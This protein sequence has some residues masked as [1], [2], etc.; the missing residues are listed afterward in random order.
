M[1]AL[2][3]LTYLYLSKEKKDNCRFKS[4]QL[5]YELCCWMLKGASKHNQNVGYVARVLK[6]KKK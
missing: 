3:T 6:L 5:R 4:H 2:E 1:Y